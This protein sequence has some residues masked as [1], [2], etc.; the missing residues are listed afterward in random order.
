[1]EALSPPGFRVDAHERSK[2][3]ALELGLSGSWPLAVFLFSLFG[4]V[5]AFAFAVLPNKSPY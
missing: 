2:P 4:G 5:E 3:E 1:M